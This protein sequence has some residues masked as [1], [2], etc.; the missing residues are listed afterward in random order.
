MKFFLFSILL[1]YSTIIFTQQLSGKVTY[2]VSMSP[3]SDKKIDSIAKK[4]KVKNIRMNNWFKTVL[5]NTSD[6]NAYLDFTNEESLYYVERK[7]QNDGK[8]LLNMNETFAGGDD[9]YYNNQITKELFH[10]SDV[11][12]ELSLIDLPI[13]KW[14]ITQETKI[15]VGY[16]CYKAIDLS[17]KNNSTY[18]WFTPQIPVSFG[19]KKFVGLPGLVLEVQLKRRKIIAA[20]IILNPK[21][22]IEIRKPIKGKKVSVEEAEKRYSSFWKSIQKQ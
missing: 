13:K 14:R 4:S 21:R 2:V 12:G 3:I 9:K 18:A 7:M 22:K 16:L 19:P 17:Y 5:K 10:Q 1:F 11:F 6:V 15:I 20:K 8:S